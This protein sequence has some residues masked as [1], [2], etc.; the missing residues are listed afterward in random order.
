[1]QVRRV[2]YN[3]MGLDSEG[4]YVDCSIAGKA[5]VGSKV[6]PANRPI[7]L[8]VLYGPNDEEGQSLVI[9]DPFK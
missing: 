7:Q 1:M 9:G 5:R 8:V 4:R 2:L 6:V 3:A